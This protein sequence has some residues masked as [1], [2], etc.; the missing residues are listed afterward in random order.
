[1]TTALIGYT[2]FV[3]SNLAAQERY[4]ELY[5]SKNIE[6]IRGRS[7]DR[8]VCAGAPGAK[9]IA[10]ENPQE[11]KANIQRLIN[12]L[13]SVD[14][15]S[16][17]L[18]STIDVSAIHA[19]G[20]HRLALED[21]VRDDFENYHIVRLPALFGPGLKKNVIYDLMHSH[22][23][24]AINPESHYQWYPIRRLSEDLGHIEAREINLVTEPIATREIQELFFP[25]L[26]IG[27]R[28]GPPVYQDI[29]PYMMMA[30]EV[31]D[32]MAQ[33]LNGEKHGR[34]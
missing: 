7:F 22:M 14:A 12:A 34:A 31:L 23:L 19:Y 10:N 33:F 29:R 5:N 4:D 2:G 16:F 11:D 25:D 15:N 26:K 8:V 24:D 20:R 27:E 18:I 17:T 30:D 32:E 1:M 13:A 9:W 28:A 3:G 21:F 6:D